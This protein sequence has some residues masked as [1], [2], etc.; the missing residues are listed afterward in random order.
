MYYASSFYVKV[1]RSF[2]WRNSR[3]LTFK[4]IWINHL[5]RNYKEFA[6][7][8]TKTL[9]NNNKSNNMITTTS[10]VCIMCLQT[11]IFV[12][13]CDSMYIILVVEIL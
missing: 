11:I 6:L 7:V 8:G 3:K 13:F 2:L 12:W 9:N 4:Y 5:F 10:N 1:R